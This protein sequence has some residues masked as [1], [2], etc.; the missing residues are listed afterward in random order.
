M[1]S[2]H[3][4]R[5]HQET[6]PNPSPLPFSLYPSNPPP[7]KTTP[8]SPTVPAVQ[9]AAAPASSKASG[10]QPSRRRL[11]SVP[12]PKIPRERLRLGS[13]SA[14]EDLGD[15]TRGVEEV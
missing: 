1:P 11:Q 6:A 3:Q 2:N 13:I 8:D 14:L 10:S 4:E 12:P 9:R 5:Q 7:P 15:A